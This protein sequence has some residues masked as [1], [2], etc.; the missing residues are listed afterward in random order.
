MNLGP[1][2]ILDDHT[3]WGRRKKR[4]L[5]WGKKGNHRRFITDKVFNSLYLQ[6]YD[7]EFWK[8]NYQIMFLSH[9]TGFRLRVG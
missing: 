4:I 8:L 3:S 2:F 7:Q 1:G 5:G 6:G 9:I